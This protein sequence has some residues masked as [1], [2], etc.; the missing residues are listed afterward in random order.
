MTQ[1]NIIDHFDVTALSDVGY[2][3]M[4]TFAENSNLTVPYL[5]DAYQDLSQFGKRSL[6]ELDWCHKKMDGNN[7][8]IL[9]EKLNY[10]PV[11][12]N[13]AFKVISRES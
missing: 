12:L 4:L 3:A 1:I 2:H 9:C 6:L 5:Y 7:W 10:D 11:K 13:Q 8:A